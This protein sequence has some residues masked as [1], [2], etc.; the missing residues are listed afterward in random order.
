MAYPLR[1]SAIP[2]EDKISAPNM[3]I[4]IQAKVGDPQQFLHN[5]PYLKS[6]N[7]LQPEHLK[8]LRKGMKLRVSD[9]YFTRAQYL[10]IRD[11]LGVFPGQQ[12]VIKEV[13]GELLQIEGVTFVWGYQ[14]FDLPE[15]L[16]KKPT[17]SSQEGY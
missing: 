12:Y 17:P 10:A 15:D 9:D 14:W 8:L 3:S 13:M 4:S 2:L 1:D 5:A 11:P 7:Q 16:R 6:S